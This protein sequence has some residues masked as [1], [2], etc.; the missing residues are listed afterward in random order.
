MLKRNEGYCTCLTT[1][2]ENVIGTFTKVPIDEEGIC[3]HC[4]Y[5]AVQG[6]VDGRGFNKRGENG[7]KKM[8]KDY[9]YYK[10][11]YDQVWNRKIR[12]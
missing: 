1:K 4:G 6:A 8:K 12:S 11:T 5:Y 9:D 2:N 3:F 10:Y 7:F